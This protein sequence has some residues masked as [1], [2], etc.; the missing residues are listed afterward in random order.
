MEI[1]YFLEKYT[2]RMTF[3]KNDGRDDI[4]P[5]KYSIFVLI[6]SVQKFQ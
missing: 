2:L 3:P 6:I 1:W 5:R 4:D